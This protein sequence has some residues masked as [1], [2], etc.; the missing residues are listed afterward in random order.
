M[1]NSKIKSVSDDNNKYERKRMNSS[2]VL[3][4][5]IPSNAVP[6]KL[7]VSAQPNNCYLILVT[8]KQ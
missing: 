1:T 3:I 8:M 4:D 6:I 5:D 2:H 7:L